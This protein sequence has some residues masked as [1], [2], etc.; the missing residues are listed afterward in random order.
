LQPEVALQALQRRVIVSIGK[1]AKEK[2][3][4]SGQLEGLEEGSGPV[5]RRICVQGT[6]AN[7]RDLTD[8]PEQYAAKQN[9]R[10]ASSPEVIVLL[11]F[12]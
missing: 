9:N 10:R 12:L 6:D 5:F 1:V 7:H 3:R 11:F 8:N 4:L 2:G